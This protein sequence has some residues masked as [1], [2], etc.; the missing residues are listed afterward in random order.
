MI[1]EILYAELQAVLKERDKPEL[2]T[3][4]KRALI[5][6]SGATRDT[7]EERIL[8]FANESPANL[9]KIR[10][11]LDLPAQRTIASGCL[12]WL[13]RQSAI[14][15]VLGIA[16]TFW[17]ASRCF[18]PASETID[19][20]EAELASPVSGELHIPESLAADAS[21]LLHP[22]SEESS[23]SISR[24]LLDSVTATAV[25]EASEKS[26]YDS[27]LLVRAELPSSGWSGVIVDRPS[28]SPGSSEHILW[29]VI[30][31]TDDAPEGV[32]Q[33]VLVSTAQDCRGLRVGDSVVFDGII[34]R[35]HSGG[36]FLDSSIVR[37]R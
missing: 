33:N 32:R 28:S 4:A 26:R 34:D 27:E 36:V 14:I 24:R 15:G 2:L 29:T 13:N 37:R 10:D 17:T 20:T 22:L 23:D 25:V 5:S 30:I 16:A 3:V 12:D 21:R 6:R 19:F 1:D 11:A 35:V 7:L 9:A 8:K 18:M 31:L